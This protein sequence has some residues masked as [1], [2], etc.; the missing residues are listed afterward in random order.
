LIS[1]LL[2]TMRQWEQRTE[3]SAV[4]EGLGESC[5]WVRV[6]WVYQVLGVV[7]V[8]WRWG[9]LVGGSNNIQLRFILDLEL[10]SALYKKY[11]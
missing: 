6:G 8:G 7:W 10:I 3:Y 1:R 9:G 5:V 2:C 4:S 11:S